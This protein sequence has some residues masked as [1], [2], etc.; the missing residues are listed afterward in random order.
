MNIALRK[1]VKID[2]EKYDGCGLCIPQCA[3]EALRKSDKNL[4]VEEVTIAITGEKKGT[5]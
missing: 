5:T 2:Q 1:I 3:E 4:P